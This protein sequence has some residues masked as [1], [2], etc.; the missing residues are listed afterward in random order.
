MTELDVLV[1]G[2]G[3][4]GLSTARE[5]AAAGLA[6]AVVERQRSVGEHVRTSGATAVDTVRRQGTPASLYH[7]VPRLRIAS[8]TYAATFEADEVFAILDVRG[9]YRWLAARAEE[10]GARVL[11]GTAATEPLVDGGAV[12]GCRVVA[13][14]EERALRA[15][16]VVDAGGHRAQLSKRSGLHPGF[17][18]FG[19]GA[20]VELEAPD[21]D[22]REAV[23]IVGERYAPAGYAWSFPWGE[24]RVRV[25]VG[26]HHADV[27]ND[28]KEHLALLLAEEGA[29][30]LGFAGAQVTEHHHGLI[31]AEGP[32]ARF[33]GDGMVAVG[34][35][36]GQATL[37]VGEGIRIALRAGV[38]AAE[39]IVA[40]L[41]AGRVDREA[42]APYEQRFLAEFGRD[43]R[44]GQRFNAR[45]A[46]SGDE[47][48]DD[49]IRLLESMPTS[50][51]VDLL[52]SHVSLRD[53]LAWYARRPRMLLRTRDLLR[54]GLSAR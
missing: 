5:L 31:P 6:T 27:R 47:R 53:V 34:D 33:A 54:A 38:L 22:Q 43:L 32:T 14:G 16:V 46:A 15:R 28:P 45:L 30:G 21:A 4:A 18:R 19:V 11:V 8:P 13:G 9:F 2:A 51:V 41:R 12:A 23:L 35:A 29:F 17:T 26:I 50:L 44:I 52:Q 42:L 37:V 36:A 24:H 48:W 25:G 3:P 39:T 1:V 40:A 7:V 49:R 20:E 10:A